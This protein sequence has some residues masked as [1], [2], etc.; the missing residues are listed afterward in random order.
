M[1]SRFSAII[2]DKKSVINSKQVSKPEIKIDRNKLMPFFLP[3]YKHNC[4]TCFGRGYEGHDETHN[5]Y[6]PCNKCRGKSPMVLD[7]R[8]GTIEKDIT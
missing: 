8:L 6:I 7:L 3:N 4:R 1:P 2:P 5:L